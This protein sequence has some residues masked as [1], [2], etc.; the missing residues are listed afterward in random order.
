MK[1]ISDGNWK[2]NSIFGI[3][4]QS[5]F[6]FSENTFNIWRNVESR[7]V[8]GE[9]YYDEEIYSGVCYVNWWSKH[10]QIHVYT[11]KMMGEVAVPR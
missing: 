11:K 3:I 2:N 1:I 4:F 5:A 7:G 6:E 8:D 10:R 9:I